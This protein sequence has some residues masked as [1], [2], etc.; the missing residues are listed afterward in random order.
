MT[1]GAWAPVAA[2]GQGAGPGPVGSAAPGNGAARS[3]SWKVRCSAVAV[4]RA[5][6]E[7]R[8]LLERWGLHPDAHDSLLVVAHELMVNGVEHGRTDVRLTV[9]LTAGGV[10]VAVHD[11]SPAPPELQAL[12]TAAPRG[13]GLQM[14]EAFAASWGWNLDGDG[15]TVWAEVPGMSGHPGPAS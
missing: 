6:R 8:G 9:G 5:R 14:I 4:A 15:K 11:G 7:L 10:R 12:H 2:D 1:A 13:R 3:A